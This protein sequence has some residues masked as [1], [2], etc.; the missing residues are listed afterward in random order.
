MRNGIIRVP[1]PKNEPV[2]SYAIGTE[3]G[4]RLQKQLDR[5][6]SET[7]EIPVIIDGKEIFTGDTGTVVCPHDHHHVLATFHRAGPK[8]I[9]AALKSSR[10]AWRDWS[11]WPWVDRAAIFL[12][13]AELLA[14]PYRPIINAATMLGQSKNTF[15]AEI[16]A[17]CETIDFLR[18]NTSFMTDIYR[19]Q[20]LSSSNI[21]NYTEYRPLEGFVFAVTPFNFTSIAA[22]LPTSA[23]LMGNVAIWKPST[24]SLYSSYYVMQL[25]RDA[26]LPPGVINFLPG[27]GAEIGA[28]LLAEADLAG[29]H[30]TGSTRTFQDIWRTIGNRIDTY[31]A[32]PRIVGETGGKDFVVIHP[33]AELDWTATALAD[34]AF[35]YQGQ[36]CSAASRAY[37]PES[38]WP[39]FR[40]AFLDR[41]RSMKMGD[42]RDFDNCVN[43]VIDAPAFDRITGYIDY[44]RKTQTILYG[45]ESDRSEGYFIQPT[46]VQ[47]SDPK[48]KLM[49]EE[50]FGPVLTVYVYPDN[51]FEETLELVNETS[52]YA[53]TG[54]IFATDRTAVIKAF[55]TLRHAAG[56]FYINDKP[57]GAVVGQQPFGGGRKSGTNDKG[58]S[59]AN[60]LRWVNT[61]SVKET[62]MSPTHYT[63]PPV[64]QR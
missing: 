19:E 45:G 4:L 60:L 31:R 58:G 28:K 2:I 39:A 26:G 59:K 48:S 41:V 5:M 57:T 13:A 11:E 62:L 12:K 23:A 37:V 49:T 32:Y 53:L 18:F 43:A 25:L 50:I 9:K 34:G 46:V 21:W 33:S 64:D 54:S 3:P 7:I 22:N 44:A 56:N 20:P 16:D 36:K 10:K 38:V 63:C 52:P 55:K 29:V 40:H 47:T 15:Q 24:T 1:D 17:A 30:F 14:D 61:R 8:E 35:G 27:A 42:V 51:R 6:A